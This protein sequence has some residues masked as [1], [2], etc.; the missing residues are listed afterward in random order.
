MKRTRT[1]ASYFS[2]I[3]VTELNESPPPPAP[4]QEPEQNIPP[5]LESSEPEQETLFAPT[6]ETQPI[7]PEPPLEEE[8]GSNR[9]SVPATEVNQTP[10]E[11]GVE[12]GASSNHV[13]DPED[14]IAD[15][16]LRKDIDEFDPNVRDDARREYVLLGPCQP[17][18]HKYPVKKIYGKNRSFHEKWYTN[19]A[20]LEYSVS[21]DAAFCF[22]C[23]LFKPLRVDNFG[24]ESFTT[25][26]FINW[27]D[28]PK[29]LDD[30]A[31]SIAHNKARLDYESYKNQRQSVT[32]AMDKGEKTGE[33][34]YKGRLIIILGVVRFL[35]LQA[36]A[37]R[38]H[39]ESANSSNKGNFLEM[40]EWYKG[41]D[42]NAARLLGIAGKN[43]TMTSPKIQKDLC[44]A[45]GEQTAKAIVKDIGDRYFAILV[46]EARD[47]S[48]KE[49]MAL[50]VRYASILLLICCSFIE[51]WLFVLIA[52]C[53]CRYVDA[54]GQV[55]ERF[56][57]IKN[58]ADTTSSALKEALDG[59]FAHYGLS[60]TRVRGQGYDGASSMRG[61][62]HGLQR[63]ILDENPHAFYIHCFAHQLQLVVVSV[64]KCCPSVF[65][66]FNITTMIVNTV[67]ASCKRRDQLSQQHHDNIVN[68]LDSGKLFSGRGKNQETNLVRPGDTR[69]GSRH[70]TLCRLQHMW[71]AVLEVL[72]NIAEDGVG[73][74]RTTASGLLLQMESFEFVFILHLMIQLLGIT[75]DLS[76][77]LQRKDQNIVRAVAL[78]GIT[79]DK[80][81]DVRQHGWDDLFEEVK[82]FSVIYQI[83]IP[84][85]EDKLTIRGRSRGRGG[86]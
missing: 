41:K 22:Y 9:A 13:L 32:H 67:N 25:N 27:K 1:L 58:V 38:G 63:K 59:M 78:I 72:E 50:I 48:I 51:Q 16:R 68:Q 69:W 34:I 6:A 65:D 46:D 55:I 82:D 26:G 42:E 19:R 45:C 33:E 4:N 49:Q 10:L 52:L 35:L 56:L 7:Q 40:I 3:P 31:N 23:Y 8:I 28:G 74:K 30:H 62:F 36:H 70:K 18:G 37:F 47:A 53:D 64:A 73:E 86:Q 54:K 79:L 71:K 57:G 15:P 11:Q 81:N 75:N 60:M 24:V 2:R 76:Q 29:L 44:K 66:F 77:C 61:E 43:H 85:M 20:W 83:I 17:K 84:D 14:I 5:P 80:I 39:D 12:D 21:K